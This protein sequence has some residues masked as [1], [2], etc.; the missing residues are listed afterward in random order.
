MTEA[1]RRVYEWVAQY[2]ARPRLA[3]DRQGDPGWARVRLAGHRADAPRSSAPEG[4][5]TGQ[6]GS[7]GSAGKRP[8]GRC[9]YA[10]QRARPH[11]RAP[12]GSWCRHQS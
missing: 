9:A 8:N 1:E 3:P 12:V 5:L 11:V 4:Y 2:I 6:A 7:S 10:H